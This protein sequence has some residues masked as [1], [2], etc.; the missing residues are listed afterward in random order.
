MVKDLQQRKPQQREDNSHLLLQLLQ[1]DLGVRGDAA[2]SC[3]DLLP[4]LLRRGLDRLGL[5]FSQSLRLCSPLRRPP[6][7][8]GTRCFLGGSGVFLRRVQL[9]TQAP[10]LCC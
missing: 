8:T 4:G 3:F 2:Q 6:L 10:Q 9:F 7:C 1:A 5:L